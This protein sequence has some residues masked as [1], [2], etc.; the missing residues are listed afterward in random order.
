MKDESS[1]NGRSRNSDVNNSI[2]VEVQGN[3]VTIKERDIKNHQWVLSKNL[4]EN[5]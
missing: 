2:Y 4:E 3:T 1:E 5:K